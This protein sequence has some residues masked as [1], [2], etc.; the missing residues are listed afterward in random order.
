MKEGQGTIWRKLS[1]TASLCFLGLLISGNKACREDYDLGSR[2]NVGTPTATQT[3]TPTPGDPNDPDDPDDPTPTSTPTPTTSS[4]STRTPTPTPTGTLT[5]TGTVTVT[6]TPTSSTKGLSKELNS[7][8]EAAPISS[9]WL[10]QAFKGDKTKD[11]DGDGFLDY[12]EAEYGSDPNDAQSTPPNPTSRLM[13]RFGGMDDDVDGLRNDDEHTR[14]TSLSSNDSDNDGCLD[15]LEGSSD[16]ADS[17]IRPDDE[18]GDCLDDDQEVMLQSDVRKFD[19]DGDGLDD[20]YE[21]VLGSDPRKVDSDGDGIT[22]AREVELGS[23]PTRAES[24]Q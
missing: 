15:G 12:L 9:N 2:T 6:P 19:T 8:S 7:L 20:G 23:D 1:F 14:G 22:D 24:R 13:A 17:T 3:P 5:P 21:F 4:E 10:G 11:S 18:D 16:P